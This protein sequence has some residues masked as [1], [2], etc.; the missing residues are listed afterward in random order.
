MACVP[1]GKWGYAQSREFKRDCSACPP[2]TGDRMA[3]RMALRDGQGPGC[4][5][6]AMQGSN[7][8]PWESSHHAGTSPTSDALFVELYTTPT[9]A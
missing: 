7:A 8:W 2:C 5:N 1:G 9:W 3:T 4:T 6:A